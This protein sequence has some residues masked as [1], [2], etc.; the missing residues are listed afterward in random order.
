M[1]E[2]SW[3][4]R[5]GGTFDGETRKLELPRVA[6]EGRRHSCRGGRFPWPLLWLIW[7]LAFI[8]KGAASL[9]APLLA[10]LSQPLVF[11]ITPLPLLLVG[12]GLGLILA[13]VVR[14]R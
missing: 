13:G 2:A 7:P 8:V 3:R 11:S 1:G 10:W 12:V 5:S 14:R 6:D 9:S 4:E